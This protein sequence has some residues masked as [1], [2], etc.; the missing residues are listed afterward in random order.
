MTAVLEALLRGWQLV[1][2]PALGLTLV[3]AAYVLAARLVDRSCPAQPWPRGR[4]VSFLA[5]VLVVA[6]AVLGPPGS[7]DDTMFAAH[8]TQHILLTL[9]A[10]PLLVLGDPVLLCLRAAPRR[11]RRRWLVP[12][13]RSRLAHRLTHPVLGWLVLTLVLVGS[14]VPAVYDYPLRHPLV[15]DYVEHPLYLGSALLFFYPLLA[16]TAGP[17]SV[18]AGIRVLSL[19]T[20]MIPASFTGFFIYV[21]PRV[22]YPFY[23]H[24]PR[25]F[26]PAPLVDQH[27]AGALMW[28][29]SMVL[30]VVWLCL[31]G[32]HWLQADA[33][34]TRRLDRALGQRSAVP[35][36]HSAGRP[37]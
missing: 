7:Y 11:V 26:G 24:V 14:H 4:T 9:V 25:P 10:A 17:R 22:A 33:T 34:R 27:L 29:S 12:A 20:V 5:G 21:T 32:L 1:P 36:E 37:A 8:M 31:A 28:S 15:H 18:P 2:V 35:P 13:L 23:A 6:V 19:F 3:A 30:S 16:P